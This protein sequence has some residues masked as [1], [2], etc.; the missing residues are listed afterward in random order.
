MKKLLSIL[1]AL[2]VFCSF[3][4]ASSPAVGLTLIPPGTVTDKVDLDI[5]AGIVNK[6]DEKAVYQVRIYLNGDNDMIFFT[7]L[8]LD[9]G[10]NHCIKYI[11]D[12]E[13]MTGKNTVCMKVS[14]GDSM[15]VLSKDF[16]VVKSEIRSTRLIDGAWAGIYHWSEEEGKHWNNDIRKMTDSQW[17]EMVRSMHGIGM[18]IIVIQEVF[19]NQ[20][21]VGNHNLDVKNYQ[22]KAFYPSELYPGRMDIAAED[23]VEAIL[24]EADRLGMSVMMG[25]GM[26]AWFDFTAESLEWHKLVAG[27]LWEKYG[28]HDSFYG[29]YVSEECAGNLFN[30]E[31]TDMMKLVRKKEISDFFREFKKYTSSLAPEKPVML[32]TNSMGVPDGADAYPALL[33]NLDILCPFGFA[34]MPD[35]D[36]T[37]K[38][39][40]DMLQGLC[41]EAGAH[42]WFDLEAFLFNPDM[43]LY[44]RP[45]DE[46]IYDLTL[47]ENFE[48]ILCYQYPG[49]FS[50]PDMSVL[51]GEKRT[52]KLYKAYKA[53]M[54][55]VIKERNN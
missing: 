31:Q 8:T 51:V 23:P 2:L 49:V 45:I 11:L 12:T 25:V 36:L 14:S 22:G 9:P 39:A 40:A 55:N 1:A 29:F 37:G 13:G 3:A 54:Q 16:E 7:E 17:R 43:S 46:I 10:E 42:L 34:R 26:F 19:R 6:S 24:S 47:F 52:E 50:N 21:Y 20:Y 4:G 53:Y 38:E 41:D 28:H 44:P 48:K 33:E 35:G 32:A 18:D 27:E 30:S 5:R 15:Y